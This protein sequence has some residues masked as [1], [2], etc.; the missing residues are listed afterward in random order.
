VNS[1][2]TA[3]PS[4]AGT[5]TTT[6]ASTWGVTPDPGGALTQ[7]NSGHL[8]G[9]GGGKYV[10]TNTQ[11]EIQIPEEDFGSDGRYCPEALGAAGSE[12]KTIALASTIGHET[13]HTRQD[14]DYPPPSKE[15]RRRIVKEHIEIYQ[16]QKDFIELEILAHLLSSEETSTELESWQRHICD[17]QGQAEDRLRNIK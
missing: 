17:L 7:P 4:G 2:G 16:D 11:N 3:T 13:A 1:G 9:T 14:A 10:G 8:V 15:E 12:A 5:I 6:G